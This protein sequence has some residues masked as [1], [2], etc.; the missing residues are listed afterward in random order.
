MF[1]RIVNIDGEE[2]FVTCSINTP[3]SDVLY[4]AAEQMRLKEARKRM[5]DPHYIAY[6]RLLRSA[7]DHQ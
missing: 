2:I 4:R 7:A 1:G 3:L 5:N 6:Q